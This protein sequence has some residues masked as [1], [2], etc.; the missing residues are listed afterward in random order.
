ML[1]LV[2][3][4]LLM[5]SLTTHQDISQIEVVVHRGANRLAPENTMAS[6]RKA[7]ELGADY[8]EV[9]VATSKDGV[10]YCFHDRRLERT[11]NGTGWFSDWTSTDIDT[12]D[13]GAWF[14]PAFAGERVPRIRDLL[15]EAKGKAKIY[16]DVKDADL[17]QLIELIKR[18]E[19]AQDCFV[20]FSSNKRALA[21]RQ[22][23][24]HLPLKMNAK[25]PEEVQ[26]L[27]RTYQPQIIECDVNLIAPALQQAC[28]EH[29]LK[30][31][32]NVIGHS[33]HEYQAAIQL[34]VD[35]VNL[36]H[37]DYFRSMLTAPDH[38]FRQHR[39][40]AHRGGIVEDLFDEFD[41]R[42]I[43]A[44]IDSG[45]WMLEIDVQPTADKQVI[46]HHDRTLQ[47][48]YGDHKTA[49]EMTLAELK[50][51]KAKNGGYAP[52]T[53]AEVAAMCR[54]KV[55]FM[56]DIKPE[57]PEAW[58]CAAIGE[59]L[60]ENQLLQGAYF[61]RNDL[62]AAF[63]GGKYGFR[64]AEVEEM[65]KR[66]A[67]GEDIAASYYLFDHGNR[68]NAET[69]RWCQK[70]SI[71]V[72]ASVNVGHYRQ[73]FHLEGARRDIEYLRKC[74]VTVFQIDSPYDAFFDLDH[75][76]PEPRK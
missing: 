1:L 56:V 42:S 39:L 2:V 5:G 34:Q 35:M 60:V 9:D 71:E 33:W 67:A 50:K 46:V 64:M 51:L 4:F 19:W 11:T 49:S 12:L 38:R 47:R 10:F 45:Y 53:F 68:I 59:A 52:M 18:E 63:D 20:W 43:E 69:A 65:K 57:K 13:A 58:F 70:N 16:F 26:E 22:K 48:I 75:I 40:V 17:D 73:E 25:T 28:Q 7:I 23:A 8:V 62:R 37:P 41:P 61:I 6:L 44:A 3:P 66:L 15:A 14:S 54:G 72:C 21:F 27:V 24:P 32:A 30:L 74:G 29:Q 55:H 76:R 36:D 31:M